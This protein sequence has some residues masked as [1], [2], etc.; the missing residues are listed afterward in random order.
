MT[1]YSKLNIEDT[2][3]E[4]EVPVVRPKAVRPLSDPLEVRAFIPGIIVEIR[5]TPGQIVREQEVLLL[6]E[7]MKMF[8]E[9]CSAGDAQVAEVLVKPGERVEKGQLLMRMRPAPPVRASEAI[10]AFIPRIDLTGR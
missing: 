3:Y 6:L 10:K 5:S 9:V 8:N 1:Q 4:T 2:I 7:A